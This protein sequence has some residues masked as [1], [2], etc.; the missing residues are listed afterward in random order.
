MLTQL[1]DAG[2]KPKPATATKSRGGRLPQDHPVIVLG[3]PMAFQNTMAE[4]SVESQPDGRPN[5]V[6]HQESYQLPLCRMFGGKIRVSGTNKTI[7]RGPRS[8]R[9]MIPLTCPGVL[10]CSMVDRGG[11][12]PRYTL[13][14]PGTAKP[15]ASGSPWAFSASQVAP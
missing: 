14:C 10:A 8:M 9:P 12:S 15:E 4:C 11:P 7:H 2:A 1:E 13:R 3:S 6:P 5:P